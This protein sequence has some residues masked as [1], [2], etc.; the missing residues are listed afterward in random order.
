MWGLGGSPGPA[1]QEQLWGLAPLPTPHCESGQ[2]I[3]KLPTVPTSPV[4]VC[5]GPS[6]LSAKARRVPGKR[7]GS[8]TLLRVRAVAWAWPLWAGLQA[9]FQEAWGPR[10]HVSRGLPA[11]T[12]T[13]QGWVDLVAKEAVP[14][15]ALL[16]L[17]PAALRDHPVPVPE[18]HPQVRSSGAPPPAPPPT[19][20][21]HQ[22]LCPGACSPSPLPG[23]LMP[24]RMASVG[25]QVT[26]SMHPVRRYCLLSR[27]Q[28]ESARPRTWMAG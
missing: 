17:A 1:A 19:E 24:R 23:H 8:V 28:P 27:N 5:P 12:L 2:A 6:R 15:F 10:P 3:P 22:G 7:D 20:G 14:L 9:G 26:V 4:L 25:A 18:P 16:E 13:A 11:D 21:R